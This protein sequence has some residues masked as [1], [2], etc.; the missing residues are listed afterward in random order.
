[1]FN[2]LSLAGKVAVVTGAASGIGRAMVE[3]FYDAGAKVVESDISADRLSELD[4]RE[5]FVTTVADIADADDVVAMV[6]LAIER[7]GAIDILVN[8]AGGPDHMFGADECTDEEW[9]QG[10][11]LYAAGPF[12]ATRRALAH[13]LPARG[14]LIINISCVPGIGGG[15]SGVAYMTGKH[16]LVGLSRN[17]AAMYAEDGIRCVAIRPGKIAT[18]GSTRLGE[19]RATGGISERTEHMRKRTEGAFL[20]R[21]EPLS[22]HGWP[23]TWPPAALTSS[24]ALCSWPTLDSPPTAGKCIARSER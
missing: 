6:D 23:F 10:L 14:G 2:E 11:A 24:M 4:G 18:G 21:A 1:V 15:R 19:L 20:R 22:T 17:V 3:A 13:M 8:N 12:L 9:L 16:A 5:G 7:F